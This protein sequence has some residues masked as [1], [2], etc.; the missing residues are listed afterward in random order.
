MKNNILLFF[1]LFTSS[2][3]SQETEEKETVQIRKKIDYTIYKGILKETESWFVVIDSD[4]TYYLLNVTI[5]NSEI[6]NWFKKFKDSQNIYKSLLEIGAYP[7][8][9]FRKENDPGEYLTFYYNG[10][11]GDLFSMTLIETNTKYQFK[12]LEKFE[13]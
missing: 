8:L 9:N 11:N 1:L 7:V 12:L 3:F 2:L 13:N 5:P 6:I 10:Q 4:N